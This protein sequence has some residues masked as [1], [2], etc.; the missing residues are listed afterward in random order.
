MPSYKKARARPMTV[1]LDP[2]TIADPWK[3]TFLR[4]Q[5]L[6][7]NKIFIEPRRP[8]D[9]TLAATRIPKG[10]EISAISGVCK[11]KKNI[12]IFAS[13]VINRGRSAREINKNYNNMKHAHA[14]TCC[15]PVNMMS[16]PLHPVLSLHSPSLCLLGASFW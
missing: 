1:L 3:F 16:H 5:L 14:R 10:E 2:S 15:T 12:C 11:V 8:P 13:S 9:S 4:L 7:T 6:H